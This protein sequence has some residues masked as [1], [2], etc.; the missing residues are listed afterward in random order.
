MLSPLVQHYTVTDIPALLPLIRKNL[1][2]NFDGWPRGSNV[3]VEELDWQILQSTSSPL[4]QRNYNF[5]DPY[6][7]DLIL[8]CDCIYH[9]SLLP[10][11]LDTLDF[12]AVPDKTAVLVVAELRSEDVIREFLG[13]WIAR[14]GW[15]IWRV[16]SEAMEALGMP[17]VVW[18][19][20]RI[21]KV[22]V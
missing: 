14:D 1:A 12:L 7:I 6:P 20:W 13:L 4:R 21:R 9:P 3:S 19:G 16:G 10:S 8:V 5:N 2:L 15:D 22:G 18:M 11:L 17:F